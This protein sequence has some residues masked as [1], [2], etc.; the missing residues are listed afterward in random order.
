MLQR[1]LPDLT[2]FFPGKSGASILQRQKPEVGPRNERPQARG[3]ILGD[4]SEAQSRQ[5]SGS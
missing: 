5:G 3:K 2:A 4:G 1:R